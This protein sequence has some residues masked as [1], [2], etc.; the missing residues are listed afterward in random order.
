[1]C[2]PFPPGSPDKANLYPL[3]LQGL[4][5]KIFLLTEGWGLELLDNSI[6]H[7]QS[8]EWRRKPGSPFERPLPQAM[9]WPRV[10]GAALGWKPGLEA[11]GPP[12]E[13]VCVT[14]SLLSCH[15]GAI[16]QEP[17]TQGKSCCSWSPCLDPF[18]AQG[19]AWLRLLFRGAWAACRSGGP[20][21]SVPRNTGSLGHAP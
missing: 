18:G 4:A 20:V 3:L 11:G 16:K 17:W 13:A 15:L 19:E 12:E 1:M 2:L 5:W 14:S 6:I 8:G 21:L 7:P 9:L 10:E